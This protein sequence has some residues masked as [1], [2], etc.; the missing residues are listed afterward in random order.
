MLNYI[1]VF[2]YI[3]VT[4]NGFHF[5]IFLKENTQ[6]LTKLNLEWQQNVTARQN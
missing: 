5:G 3:Y 4:S 6:Y 2:C 1:Y